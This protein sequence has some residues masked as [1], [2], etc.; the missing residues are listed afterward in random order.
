MS[1]PRI[2]RGLVLAA[3]GG[4]LLAQSPIPMSAPRARWVLSPGV[5]GTPT[6]RRDNPGAASLD[7]LYVFRRSLGQCHDHRAERAL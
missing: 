7:R 6:Q 2:V 1:S 4:S 5:T 3:L